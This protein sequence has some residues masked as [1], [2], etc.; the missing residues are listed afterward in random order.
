[1]PCLEWRACFSTHSLQTIMHTPRVFISHFCKSL[2]LLSLSRWRGNVHSASVLCD[3]VHSERWS[4]LQLQRQHSWKQR[5]GMLPW[6]RTVTVG[7]VPATTRYV[8]CEILSCLLRYTD[9]RLKRQRGSAHAIFQRWSSSM[10]FDAMAWPEFCIR[11]P[12]VPL[13]PLFFPLLSPCCSVE[14][15]QCSE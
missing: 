15:H 14:L 11:G 8:C 3:A 12:G 1:M 5:L 9:C 2:C 4:V 10:L 13:Y 6:R 7:Q